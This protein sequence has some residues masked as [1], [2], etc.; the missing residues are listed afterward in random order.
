MSQIINIKFARPSKDL[1]EEFL[2]NWGRS[3]TNEL[4]GGSCYELFLKTNDQGSLILSHLSDSEL[5]IEG[6]TSE[7]AWNI[8]AKFSDKNE[9]KIYSDG[10][11]IASPSVPEEVD[12]PT[13]LGSILAIL[14]LIA[15]LLIIPFTALYA[16][17][18]FAFQLIFRRCRS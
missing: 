13:L 7:A 3:G 11:L 18:K 4:I 16:V 12:N 15:L 2:Q 8:I 10:Q 17:L 14:G 5:Q 1:L 6:Y 9:A